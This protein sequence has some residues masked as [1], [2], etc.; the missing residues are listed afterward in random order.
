MGVPSVS[1]KRRSRRWV[2]LWLVLAWGA[3]FAWVF[4]RVVDDR[5][6]WL[7]W[8][9]WIPTLAVLGVGSGALVLSRLASRGSPR[10][11]PRRRRRWAGR[12]PLIALSAI[13]VYF[14]LVECRVW[15]VGRRVAP[16]DRPALRIL[17][18]NA[19]STVSS[20][21]TDERIME[22][23]AD[24]LALANVPEP[25]EPHDLLSALGD[26][27]R[28]V[29]AGR[30]WAAS[31][32]PILRWGATDLGL[33][34]R[35]L[36]ISSSGLSDPP[37]TNDEGWALFME[38]DTVQELGR[39]TVVWILDL[40]SDPTLSRQKMTRDVER[41][42]TQWPGPAIMPDGEQVEP[43]QPGFPDPDVIVGD[44]N[45]PRG[46]ASLTR[47]TRGMP[48]AFDQGGFGY[49]ATWPL[50]LPIIHIDH[51]FVAPWL[52]CSRYRIVRPGMGWHAQQVIDLV[53]ASP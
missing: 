34:G 26:G 43:V 14:A 50:P 39:T 23:G 28:A 11:A 27:S 24:V 15:A 25:W 12:M 44:M 33:N 8:V 16:A 19:S 47:L 1:P 9:S 20:R 37:F 53:P 30:I 48:H 5:V 13:G 35:V 18:W 31:R 4:G 41:A 10:G 49:A 51:A 42:I 38:L 52:E 2:A 40:P 29:R 32:A 36:M 22:H 17:S 7:Q 3:V 45:T 6:G 21:R 46:A